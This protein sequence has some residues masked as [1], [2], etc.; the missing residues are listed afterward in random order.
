MEQRQNWEPPQTKGLKQMIPK[1][2]TFMADNTIFVALGIQDKYLKKA[3]LIRSTLPP[4][5]YK[6]SLVMINQ[7]LQKFCHC[8]ANKSAKL[9]TSSMVNHHIF[10]SP[11]MF[12]TIKQ[13]SPQSI[14]SFQNQTY[15]NLTSI[16]KYL[17]KTSAKLS[18]GYLQ[19]LNKE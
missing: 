3:T 1:D 17:M 11:C 9:R 19:L 12:L 13:P 16:L 14:Q 10:W 18:R 8:I 15:I 5:S 2:C 6:T 7:L 4:A